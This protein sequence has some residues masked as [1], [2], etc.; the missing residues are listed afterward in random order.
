MILP[1]VFAWLVHFYT[2]LGAVAAFVAMLLIEDGRFREAFW[3]MMAAVAI[4]A[5]DG[6]FARAAR[7]K[8]RLPQFDGDRLEDIVD[9]ANYVVVPSLLVV[10]ANLLPPED[11]LWLASLPLIASA[12]GFC[13]KEAKTADNFFLGFPSYWNIVALYLYV[14]ATPPWLNAFIIILLSVLVFVPI[15]YVY[16]SR[17]RHFPMLTNGLAILWGLALLL[18]IYMLPTPPRALVFAS[19]LFPAYYIGLSLWLEYRRLRS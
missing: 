16:P 18:I 14:L 11:A 7:V 17:T 13:Q 4:D 8:E 1:F 19:L 12:Y 2:A 6:T 15:R 3:V 10:R 5:S 9:Y